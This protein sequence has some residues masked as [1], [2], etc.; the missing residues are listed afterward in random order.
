[1]NILEYDGL[2]SNHLIELDS[3]L[4]FSVYA[5]QVQTI[6][7]RRI[8]IHLHLIM[9]CETTLHGHKYFD[10]PILIKQWS[11]CV[12]LA[13][14]DYLI[15]N[16]HHLGGFRVTLMSTLTTSYTGATHITYQSVE[17]TSIP[18][19][20]TPQNNSATV[21]ID[22][23]VRLGHLYYKQW[24]IECDRFVRIERHHNAKSKNPFAGEYNGCLNAG[25]QIIEN[26]TTPKVIS[27]YGPYCLANEGIPLMGKV[28]DWYMPKGVHIIIAYAYP[29][30]RNFNVTFG[31]FRN[32]CEGVTNMC[33]K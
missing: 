24:R 1:M 18:I 14:R 5:I 26:S 8:K 13:Q 11:G 3:A 20:L 4:Q 32:D 27:T 12:G 30:Y 25:W 33:T 10:G 9:T 6:I 16:Y 21:T 23:S 19:I 29:Q 28:S 7:G 2:Q 22:T 17:V 15:H 31:L